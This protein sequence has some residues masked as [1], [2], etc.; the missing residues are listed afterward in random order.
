MVTLRFLLQLP[1]AVASLM[2]FLVNEARTRHR[3]TATLLVWGLLCLSAVPAPFAANA[4]SVEPPPDVICD[5]LSAIHVPQLGKACFRNGL[6]EVFSEDGQHL[7]ATHG[8]DNFAASASANWMGEGGYNGTRDPVCVTDPY[9]TVLIYAR[10][11]GTT[12]NYATFVPIIRNMTK[13]M[14]WKINEAAQ[15]SGTTA[16]LRVEC[17]ASGEIKV[18]N[19]V[20]DF[21]YYQASFGNVTAGI[22]CSV[23]PSFYNNNTLHY[24]VLYDGDTYHYD[25]TNWVPDNNLCGGVGHV[26]DDDSMLISNPNNGNHDHAHYAVQWHGDTNATHVCSATFL[27]EWS[28]NSGAVV[29]SAPHGTNGWHCTDGWDT[30]CYTDG[31]TDQCTIGGWDCVNTCMTYVEYDCRQDDYFNRT[32]QAGNW[33]IDHWNLGNSRTCCKHRYLDFSGVPPRVSFDWEPKPACVGSWVKFTDT[34][35]NGDSPLASRVWNFTDLAAGTTTS[36]GP[37]PWTPSSHSF[38]FEQATT[39]HVY[40]NV[41]DADGNY[42][43]AEEDVPVD[44]CPQTWGAGDSVNGELMVVG[45]DPGCKTGPADSFVDRPND[46]VQ[47]FAL[48]GAPITGLEP[49]P[50]GISLA[51]A[52]ARAGRL[53]VA[54]GTQNCDFAP[55]SATWVYGGGWSGGSPLNVKRIDPAAATVGGN[56]F[57]AG[58]DKSGGNPTDEDATHVPTPALE[59]SAGGSWTRKQNMPAGLIGSSALA[60]GNQ[61]VVAGGYSH[62]QQTNKFIQIYDASSGNWLGNHL[63]QERTDFGMASC[64]DTERIVVGGM[65]GEDVP[66]HAYYDSG[67]TNT[68]LRHTPGGWASTPSLPKKTAFAQVADLGPWTFVQGG[69]TAPSAGS[70]IMASSQVVRL[71]CPGASLPSLPLVPVLTQTIADGE[72]QAAPCA[73]SLA[74]V[75]NLPVSDPCLLLF[76]FGGTDKAVK[77]GSIYEPGCPSDHIYIMEPV[78]GNV[79]DLTSTAATL[80]LSKKLLLPVA[81][82][83]SARLDDGR[84]VIVGGRTSGLDEKGQPSCYIPTDVVQIFDP[85]TLTMTPGPPLPRGLIAPAVTVIGNTVYVVGGDDRGDFPVAH[86]PLPSSATDARP[87][88]PSAARYSHN[89][90]GGGG[91]AS[92]DIPLAVAHGR[93]SFVSGRDVWLIGGTH[94]PLSSVRAVQENIAGEGNGVVPVLPWPLAHHNAEACVSSGGWS[95][96]IFTGGITDGTVYHTDSSSTSWASDWLHYSGGLWS[97]VF[98]P[99]IAFSVGS[100]PTFT[101]TDTGTLPGVQRSLV[102]LPMCPP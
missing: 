79:I 87:R 102:S 23:T 62:P 24:L 46:I 88:H 75:I 91:W 100:G 29:S 78:D 11:N 55:T 50:G 35:E 58:G 86:F 69:F 26:D 70:S 36:Y 15:K 13:N 48:G 60:N 90:A 53:Y 34:S 49:F 41:T 33:L 42:T 40:L 1:A 22:C 17:E 94:H 64:G 43:V 82:M 6:Y 7:G 52:S 56:L 2:R 3:V 77:K 66:M 45:N 67:A 95:G 5:A 71:N 39:I 19:V 27:H 37:E 51:G 16:D 12:D 59:Q 93:L 63:P 81:S 74:S 83:G 38:W 47:S 99:P 98:G 4:S 44:Y 28:H 68:V 84:I 8:P 76:I 18:H 92:D 9:Y 20:L 32:P 85:V 65:V 30:M 31:S 54:G 21:P 73:P 61:L 57:W 14:N 101:D 89:F 10:A 25:G 96:W 80:G 97:P 72:M